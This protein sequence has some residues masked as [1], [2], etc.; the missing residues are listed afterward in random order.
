MAG[1]Q[2]ALGLVSVNRAQDVAGVQL[3]L[4]MNKAAHM[5]GL[6]ISLFNSCESLTGVQIGLLNRIGQSPL[7]F[8]PLIN[9]HF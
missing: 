8:L 5:R 6:Q 2:I 1:A 9:A 4:L 7:P 3:A